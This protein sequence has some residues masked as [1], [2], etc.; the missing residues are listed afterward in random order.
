M[1]S[2][3]IFRKYTLTEVS[4]RLDVLP[5]ELSRY[6]GQT[7]GLPH[8]ML[9]DDVDI[10]KIKSEM[11]LKSWWGS[12]KAETIEDSNGTRQQIRHLSEMILSHG[13]VRAERADNLLRGLDGEGQ[14]LVRRYINTLLRMGI[15]KSEPSISSLEISLDHSKKII[16]EEIVKGTRYPSSM[17]SL[18]K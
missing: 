13:L 4:E 9:F 6:F 17:E 7:T 8:R 15:L 3:R 1:T 18:W 16:L 12:R 14:A 10:E 2:T 5:N 11:G